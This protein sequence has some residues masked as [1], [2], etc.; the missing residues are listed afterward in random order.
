MG[1][2]TCEWRAE[3]GDMLEGVPLSYGPVCGKPA[4]WMSCVPFVRTP[5][6]DKHKCRCAKPIQEEKPMG[7]QTRG[8]DG[9]V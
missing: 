1:E 4:R 7:E 2:Q 9:N 8:S 3:E 5:T 6:C